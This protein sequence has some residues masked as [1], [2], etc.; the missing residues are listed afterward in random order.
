MIDL[1]GILGNINQRMGA[2]RNAASSVNVQQTTTSDTISNGITQRIEHTEQPNISNGIVSSIVT[3][4]QDII[5]AAG[6]TEQPSVEELLEEVNDAFREFEEDPESIELNQRA[7]TDNLEENDDF[8]GT[9]VGDAINAAHQEQSEIADEIDSAFSEA[10]QAIQDI[11]S[12]ASENVPEVAEQ[13]EQS[14][15]ITAEAVEQERSHTSTAR[16]SG[17][18]WFNRVKGFEV[19]IFGVGG[20]G[21]M[22]AFAV[23]RLGVSMLKCYDNDII[24]GY[25]IAGQL[26]KSSMVGMPKVTAIRE[27]I[28]E[29]S[30][31]YPMARKEIVNRNTRSGYDVTICCFD[32][33][34]SRKEAFIGW[35]NS[36][37]ISSDA[38]FIDA[39][40]NLE[41]FQIFAFTK[42]DAA[43]IEKYENEWLFSDE[44]ARAEVCSMKQTT[45]CSMMIG[46][47]I[48]NLIVNY[49][50]ILEGD[51]TRMVPFF[52]EYTAD[53]M[54]LNK[55]F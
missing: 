29:F 10:E 36:T 26:Y 12:E 37:S 3:A 23:S 54:F 1:D 13:P 21:S 32:N 30:S 24:E 43:Y 35:K 49:A 11:T 33:M 52:T 50:S 17:A 7:T 8:S 55:K 2:A 47:T 5:A 9:P 28:T 53:D 25:N 6:I 40:M 18:E 44:E 46:A 22:A 38:L 27:I 19:T 34:V 42:K 39:R 51:E 48:A 20:I 31:M 41:K 16:F 45:F 14:V 15:E 4:A